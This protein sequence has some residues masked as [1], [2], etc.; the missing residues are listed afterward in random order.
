MSPELAKSLFHATGWLLL[1]GFAILPLF[2]YWKYGVGRPQNLRRIGEYLAIRGLT[3]TAGKRCEQRH[4][5]N[6]GALYAIRYIDA[7]GQ[8]FE[9]IATFTVPTG[10]FIGEQ[11]QLSAHEAAASLQPP[12]DLGG[13]SYLPGKPFQLAA[14]SDR[15]HL[16]ALLEENQNL[17]QQLAALRDQSATTHQPGA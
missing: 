9:A 13:T 4:T 3:L 6:G 10:V 8:E 15:A 7:Q 5:V 14:E 11:R 17:K 1:G 12:L 16:Q 2:L